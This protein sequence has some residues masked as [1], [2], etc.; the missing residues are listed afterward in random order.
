M[1]LENLKIIDLRENSIVKFTSFPKSKKLETVL[2]SFNQITELGGF[3]NSPNIVTFDIKNNKLQALSDEIF[4]LKQMKILDL[5]NN[6]LQ[7]LP[8]ELGLLK[9]LSKLQVEGNPLKTIRLAVRQGGS[10]TIKKYLASRIDP[11]STQHDGND[12]KSALVKEEM[13]EK[14][15]AVSKLALLIR[16]FKNPNGDLDLKG[17]N[18]TNEDI[19]ED[20]IKAEKVKA[21]DLSQNK[22]HAIPQHIERVNP[23]SLKLNSNAIK[24]VSVAEIINFTCL[25]EIEIKT[26]KMSSFCD[27]Q[28][29]PEDVLLIQMNFAQLT[30]LDLSQNNISRV[31]PVLHEFKNLRS[32][33][34]AY[35]SIS[36]LED[37]FKEG[38]IPQI[39]HLDLSNNSLTEVPSR[40]Y[41]WQS[42]SSLIIQ[43]NNIKNFPP[44]LGFLNLKNLNITGNPS[45]LLK[46][47]LANRGVS[48]IL[49]YLKDRSPNKQQLEAEVA[50]IRSKPYAVHLPKKKPND[51]VEYEFPDPFK[52]K[53]NEY[54]SKQDSVY[55]EVYEEDIK[56]KLQEQ[57]SRRMD[58]EQIPVKKEQVS[59]ARGQHKFQQE[60]TTSVSNNFGDMPPKRETVNHALGQN[61][62]QQTTSV[63]NVFGEEP[64]PREKGFI[65]GQHKNHPDQTTGVSNIFGEEPLPREKG[66][67]RGQHKNHPDQT[68]GVSNIFGEEPIKRDQGFIR[69]QHNNHPD[70]TTG[71]SN[72]FG[73]EP[74]PREKGFIRGQHKNH[75]DQT[76]GV[77]NVF[78]EEPL[79]R[80]KGFIRGQHKNHPDQTTGV[81]NIFGE[82]PIPREQ[83]FIRGQHK[84]HPDQTTG[85]SNVFGEEPIKREQGF[86]R[87]QHKNHPDQTTGVSNVF[88]EEPL[89]REKGF[90]RGQHKNHPDQTTGV[91]NIF[92]EEPIKREQGFI[93]GQHSKY[94]EQTS[95]VADNFGGPKSSLTSSQVISQS[96]SSKQSPSKAR[97]EDLDMGGLAPQPAGSNKASDEEKKQLDA[98]IKQLQDKV[99]NDY[100]LNKSK[101]AELKK[102]LM[103]LRVQRNQLN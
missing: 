36:S 60:Q 28:L 70:Q 45:L 11:N 15:S 51:L 64:L 41:K 77:S 46:G 89:P 84:N 82:E 38:G 24:T 44:E 8:P 62:F 25:K 79:P 26:N 56:K 20:I 2:L 78:G 16:Q 18:L 54:N 86:I 92:G 23:V 42:M 21:L 6:D 9:N 35:N 47:A 85:V 29:I 3:S 102:E 31:P 75:P 101:I 81:S 95:S 1:F 83:G 34:L 5:S 14:P 67:I 19:T 52:Q 13:Q 50:Q 87:G 99:D 10:E 30:Y 61:K 17:K 53:P 94:P 97:R 32:L 72:V 7:N 100:T 66:F 80:E 91:S 98:K 40:I 71:V 93:R 27:E 59:F 68:T 39:D 90:I 55:G 63:S 88:G 48:G 12:A 57:K 4:V 43:N 37:L 49:E 58:E 69:G 74:L 96:P 73:E 65:R 33:I 22:L 76:T 103:Q